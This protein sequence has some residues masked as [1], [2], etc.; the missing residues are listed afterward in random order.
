MAAVAYVPLLWNAVG[1]VSADT[2]TYLTLDPGRLLGRA[3]S[4]WDPSIGLG[5]VTHQTIG[6]LFPL[7][8]YYWV[9]DRLGVPDWLT[10]R[11]WLGSILFAA[12]AG[13]LFLCR[14]LGWRGRGAIVAGFAYLLSPYV[15]H[16]AARISVI[17]LPWAALPW[18]IACTVLA[19]RRGGW[20]WPAVFALVTLTVGGVNATSLV[21]AGIGPLLWLP[22]AVWVTREVSLRRA[23]AA[24]GRIAVLTLG[25]SVWW[26]VG[27]RLQGAYGLPIL[28]F[29]ES[30]RTIADASTAPEILRG[31]G[32]W[33][34]YGGDPVD[35]WVQ[36]SEP[37]M[38]APWL[39]VIG[40]AIP[41]LALLAAA[42]V[43]WSHRL[44]AVALVV[45]GVAVAVGAHPYDD[46][47]VFGSLVKAF[48]GTTA[49]LALRSTPRAIPLVAL[50][51][52]LLLG[53]GV[54]AVGAR[55]PR[56]A[57][58]AALGTVLL[59]ALNL[60]SL[61]VGRLFTD[62]LLRPQEV[63]SAYQRA[64]AALGDTT[65]TRLYELPG[66]DFA[67][68]RW[69][70]TVDPITPGLTDRPYVARE[71]VPWG[72]PQ[73]ADLLIAYERRLQEGWFEP[74]SLAPFA[75]L[76]SAG[77]V[78]ARN[79]LQYE[80]YLTP[81]PRPTWAVLAGAPGLDAPVAYG[82]PTP[83]RS[84]DRL[85]L[86][87]EQALGLPD[88]QPDAPPV[89]SFGVPG[90]P[91]IVRTAPATQAVVVA[92]S[93]DG[94][95]D[96][97]GAGLLDG[98]EVVLYDAS[99]VDRPDV[100]Q[101]ALAGGAH[102]VVTDSNRQR[103]QRWGAV[104][105]NLGATEA[106]GE[107]ALVDDPT[108]NRLDTF[109]G[110]GSDAATVVERP[111]V[112][113]VQATGYGN[114]VTYTPEDRP[115]MALDGDPQTAWRVGAF[116]P[117]EGE[118]LV[119][120]LAQPV[121]ADHLTLLQPTT[122]PRNRWITEARLTFDGT[123]RAD[124]AL[125]DASRTTPGQRVDISVDGRPR[126]FQT[127]ELEIT[128]DT[129]G[130]LPGYKGLTSVGLA[131]LGIPG[132]QAAEVVR[133]P[134]R[135][136]REAAATGEASGQGGG[137][138]G[139]RVTVVLTRLRSDPTNRGRSDEELRIDRAV[140]LP[141]PSTFELA[142]TVR[143]DA[144][145]TD[146]LVDAA[147]GEGGAGGTAGAGGAVTATSSGRLLGSPG[148]RAAAAVDGDPSTR[149]ITPMETPTGQAITVR[150]AAPA[151][152][153]HLDLEVVADGR[154]SVPTQL[155]LSVD[156]GAPITV[157]V[158]P[159]ADDTSREGATAAVQVPLPTPL[160]GHE[161]VARID[162]VREVR[163]TDYFSGLPLLQPAA[164]AELGLPGVTQPVDPGR[165]LPSACRD[166]LVTVD[167][168]PV[169][170]RIEGTVGQA[171][172]RQP[173]PLIAC[174]G[175][176]S[177]AAGDHH[178]RTAIGRDLGLDVDRLVLDTAPSPPVA[179]AA[180]PALT[181]EHEDAT[182]YR[183]RVDGATEPF[184]LVLG[185]SHSAGWEANLQG[186]GSL[187]EPI[188]LNGY[189]NGW[190]VDPAAAG[191]SLTIELRWAPQR[192]VWVGLA[193]SG[194][195]VLACLAL[196]VLSPGRR[197]GRDAPAPWLDPTLA[198]P[199]SGPASDALP[200]EGRLP[201]RGV[202]VPLGAGLLFGF[203]AGPLPALAAAAVGALILWR[204]RLRRVLVWVP[205][206]FLTATTVYVVT[207]LVRFDLPPTLDWPNEFEITHTWA[208]A[209]VATAATL[210]VADRWLERHGR[211]T[212]AGVATP[213]EGDGAG[214]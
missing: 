16:Y 48:M 92:G 155:A 93:G 83:N 8:P 160:T 14:T 130:K 100:L 57:L 131:E 56:F 96:L 165:A 90:A 27:L 39:I 157:D 175:P 208:W 148:S 113:S 119:V 102:L 28:R 117:V 127:V 176:L 50:G 12:G 141:A 188:V 191:G 114:P 1:Q 205:P 210:A 99:L 159:V 163:Q 38:T 152:V 59:V 107:R 173:L 42:A 67:S 110:A 214:P 75:R 170:V 183:V 66:I 195:A 151:T 193:V 166:D 101:S 17:L 81:R 78:V 213:G 197:R 95:V 212:S 105:E 4:L 199:A 25:V 85:P 150:S 77:D 128:G 161:F 179:P 158:P 84:I 61:F 132:V 53:A 97:A 91:P 74:A 186:A 22:Y 55:L 29:T 172:A 94:L 190:L 169:R 32:Y 184:W 108:D 106:V 138:A 120:R 109:P 10:Q 187:G 34:F 2:K 122:G 182:S 76:V 15:L 129:F 174:D 181:V 126:T 103:G 73:G 153:D 3:V 196:V 139:H 136:L 40:Y 137:L 72:S 142:G 11:L 118:R 88:N 140:D 54:D 37:Y 62:N 143:L 5:T 13:V 200:G 33:F 168:E 192:L 134:T 36:P 68:Y 112:A 111:G 206:A 63:P 21:L 211:A 31:L 65:S 87:D 104:R 133:V 58:P 115:A 69:G 194:A 149:W 30:Y 144:R 80:R 18:L 71:L 41:A 49:G 207:K 125:G 82:P 185:Q 26:I 204:P 79:D 171:L 124:V 60:P 19:L 156:G 51:A 86:L 189:A 7:G 145:A 123:E 20:R 202:I 198:P 147:L 70:G 89:A 209:A 23:L 43:R 167:G 52:A 46:P 177:L 180:G 24:S 154:F 35:A 64:V 121:T 201:G 9:M 6:Y 178:V 162:A 44:Y 203:L 164:I 45:V 98:R 47:S 146:E 135:L 116:S